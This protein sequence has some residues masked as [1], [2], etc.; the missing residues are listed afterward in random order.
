MSY[1]VEEIEMSFDFKIQ[2]NEFYEYFINYYNV[3]IVI[4][5]FDENVMMINFEILM[6]FNE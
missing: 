5:K 6:Q 2:I 4:K 3:I 1:L